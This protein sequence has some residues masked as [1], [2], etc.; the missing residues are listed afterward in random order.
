M[1]EREWA[2]EALLDRELRE[3]NEKYRLLV[4]NANEAILVAQ[5]EM[6]RFLNPKTVDLTGYSKEE[7]TSHPF[8]SFIH[9]EDREIVSDRHQKRM[10]GE[11]PPGIYPFRLVNKDGTIKWVETNT[12]LIFWES[13]PATLNFL[14]DITA[15]KQVEEALKESERRY[16][17]LAENAH[18]MIFVFD[19]NLKPTYISPSVKHLS[20]YIVEEAMKHRLDQVLTPDSYKKLME[21]FE[22]EVSLERSGQ[23]HGPDWSQTIEQEILRKNGSTVWIEITLNIIYNEES[24]PKSILGIARDITER[25][26][27]ALER[28]RLVSELQQAL[29]N[30]K[31]LSG[32]LP[33]CANCKKIRDDKGYWNQIESYISE[34]SDT[35]FSHGI[36][37]ECV[38]KLYPDYDR[39]K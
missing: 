5:D 29:A 28:E 7:L 26:R 25:K 19:F 36:C 31:T 2:E 3:L 21:I 24:L 35:V 33:I 6:I 30:V 1:F 23:R 38:K 13:R 14:S 20:G 4:E 10:N 16:R 39:K 8:A 32:L 17:M 9:S 22:R 15:R 27:S 34:H 11:D 37:P 12:V 18:D